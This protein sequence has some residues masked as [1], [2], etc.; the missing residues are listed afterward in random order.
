MHRDNQTLQDVVQIFP[1][2][3]SIIY[4]RNS[5]CGINLVQASPAYPTQSILRHRNHITSYPLLS[6]TSSPS[7]SMF[8]IQ[9][10][11]VRPLPAR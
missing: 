8:A 11:L 4:K 9:Y 2:L 5:L 6:I 7:R 3:S 10:G 1:T